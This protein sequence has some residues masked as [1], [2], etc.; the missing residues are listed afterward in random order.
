MN[1]YIIMYIH[2]MFLAGAVQFLSFLLDL[3][4]DFILA[5]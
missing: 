3:M 2:V 5:L 1:L 4:F